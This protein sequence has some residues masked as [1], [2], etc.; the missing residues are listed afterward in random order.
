M[1]NECEVIKDLLPSYIAGILSKKTDES[2]KEHIDNC[3][4]CQKLLETMSSNQKNKKYT[5][6]EKL[7]IDY[8]KKY[9]KKMKSLKLI[10]LSIILIL[11]IVL[12]IFSIKFYYN[13]NIM[14]SVSNNIKEIQNEN[15]YTIIQTEH[16]IDYL[17]KSEFTSVHKYYY[18]DNKYKTENHIENASFEVKNKDIYYYGKINDNNR[19]QIVEDTK[20]VYRE[21]ANYNF[22]KKGYFINN[23]KNEIGV[24]GEDFGFFY[25]IYM[26][27][28]YDVRNDRF[29]GK[30][31][32]VLKQE[33]NKS[34]NELWIDKDS[35]LIIRTIQD[36]Y[37]EMFTEKIYNI[38]I[39][40][41]KDEDLI[42]P[43]LEGYKEENIN[44]NINEEYIKLYED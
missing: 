9:H 30:N 19:I 18:K 40:S 14:K 11:I 12:S 15:N 7:Q 29:N 13:I 38:G 17:N 26:K 2:I 4:N 6:D 27:I 44:L 23:L 41:V 37:N 10:I 31:C 39:N 35:M 3:Y 16:T 22:V 43:N 8:L 20:T 1:K 33:S 5:D 24:F 28:G 32:Y 34:K 25:N 36:I 42:V 21:V